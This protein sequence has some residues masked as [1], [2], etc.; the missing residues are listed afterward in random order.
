MSNVSVDEYEI[1]K[2]LRLSIMNKA[3]PK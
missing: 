2:E 3:E 1:I